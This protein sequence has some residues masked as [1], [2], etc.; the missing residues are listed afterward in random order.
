MPGEWFETSA[1]GVSDGQAP[2]PPGAFFLAGDETFSCL[3]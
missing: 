1:T 3:G 2:M